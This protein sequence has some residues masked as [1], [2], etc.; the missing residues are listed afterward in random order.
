M[1]P[2]QDN[3]FTRKLYL[4]DL[5][6]VD[7]FGRSGKFMASPI[8][9][10]LERVEH[11]QI[12]WLLEHIPV[13]Y[14]MGHMTED[15]AKVLLQTQ[16]ESSLYDTLIGRN[17]NFRLADITGIWNS[18]NPRVYFDRI[19]AEDGDAALEVL[20]TAPPILLYLTHD[21][22]C[23]G[24]IFFKAFHTNLKIIHIE[25]HPIDIVASWYRKRTV[26]LVESLRNQTLVIRKGDQTLPW[27]AAGWEDRYL[28]LSQT[29]RLVH[30][31]KVL[32]HMR[33]TYLDEVS[34]EL[35]Q[36]ICMLRF[37][38]FISDPEPVVARICDFLGTETTAHTRGILIR[39][40]CPRDVD[41][42]E[43]LEKLNIL[44]SKASQEAIDVL[45]SLS[46]EYEQPRTS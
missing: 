7:G 18:K 3:V 29:D 40:R 6:F 45:M 23:H 22:L 21:V 43:R 38:D 46:S 30:S 5:V 2:K 15:A 11:L 14:K 13:M 4:K 39:E 19:Q 33:K 8:V 34:A 17:A 1:R 35:R 36:R 31:F 9:A 25:R 20:E 16:V 12:S 32:N 10:S 44:R 28:Q 27:Y 24:D 42:H 37:E 26:D 41:P